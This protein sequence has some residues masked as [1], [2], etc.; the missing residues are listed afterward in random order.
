MIPRKEKSFHYC[1]V[2]RL[3]LKTV[4]LEVEQYFEGSHGSLS[5]TF[6][7]A[8]FLSANVTYLLLITVI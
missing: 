4:Y 6:R 2:T 3:D 8:G 1:K 7:V 5:K